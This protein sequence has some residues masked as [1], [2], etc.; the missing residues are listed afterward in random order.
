M[1]PLRLKSKL[2]LSVATEKCKELGPWL[3]VPLAVNLRKWELAV[4]WYCMTQKADFVVSA[5]AGVGRHW[6]THFA[7]GSHIYME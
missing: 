7:L 6:V 1:K 2:K 5:N 3:R 4:L